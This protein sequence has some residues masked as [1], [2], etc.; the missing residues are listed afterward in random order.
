MSITTQK[1]VPFGLMDEGL[2]NGDVYLEQNPQ[3][4]AEG[5]KGFGP[6]FPSVRCY[7][8]ASPKRLT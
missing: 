5:H 7:A 2:W 4:Q 6:A 1:T 3:F 8:E